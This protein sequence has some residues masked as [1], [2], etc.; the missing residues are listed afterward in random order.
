MLFSIIIREHLIYFRE[1]N[2][3]W[4]VSFWLKANIIVSV[5]NYFNVSHIVMYFLLKLPHR[6]LKAALCD[7]RHMYI[8]YTQW[9]HF[10]ADKALLWF[11]Q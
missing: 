7:I 1:K 4:N 9:R 8:Q 6:S 2:H 11:E 5:L 3:Y 10:H